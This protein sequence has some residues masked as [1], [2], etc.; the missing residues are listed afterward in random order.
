MSKDQQARWLNASLVP[1]LLY[2]G[3]IFALSSIPDDASFS[4]PALLLAY[5]NLNNFL[6][7]PLFG[8]LAW[9]WLGYLRQTLPNNRTA[10]ILCVT[11]CLLFAL[12]DEL[13]QMFV[14]GRFASVTDVLL[15]VVGI[16]AVVWW[17]R[18]RPMVAESVSA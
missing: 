13:H 9:L 6:H 16:L 18:R 2:M 11:I 1:P 8:G 4:G 7:I 17:A 3:F 5:P 14:P 10:E 12:S 15:D